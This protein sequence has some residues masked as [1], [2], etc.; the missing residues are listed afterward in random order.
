MKTKRKKVLTLHEK[1]LEIYDSFE[2]FVEKL[3]KK[4]GVR[5]VYNVDD[6]YPNTQ[7]KFTVTF[8]KKKK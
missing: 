6:I 2:S 5:I 4:H 7:V 1:T 3:E 8:N